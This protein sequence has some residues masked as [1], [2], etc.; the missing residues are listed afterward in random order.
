MDEEASIPDPSHELEQV[1]QGIVVRSNAEA[2]YELKLQGRTLSQIA[3]QLGYSSDVEVAHAL[4]DQMKLGA[5]HL[6]ESGRNGILQMEI[7]RLERLHAAY[8]PS[9]IAGDREDAKLVLTIMDRMIKLGKLDAVDTATQGH[10]VLVISGEEQSY[11]DKLRS[12]V[13]E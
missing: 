7:D 3:D 11:V 10:T 4:R 9:A 5:Q 2:A 8:Y 13:D 1:I 6:S 12:L